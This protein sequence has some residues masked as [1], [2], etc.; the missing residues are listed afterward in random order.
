MG[1]AINALVD[2]AEETS[3]TTQGTRLTFLDFTIPKTGCREVFVK[4]KNNKVPHKR[5]VVEVREVKYLRDGF[6]R[7]ENITRK[8]IL[9]SFGTEIVREVLEPRDFPLAQG[10]KVVG[11]VVRDL[12][13]KEQEF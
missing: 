10:V 3:E 2:K 8:I 13:R 9:E 11:Q 7:E 12:R 4:K 1:K 6:V 5:T